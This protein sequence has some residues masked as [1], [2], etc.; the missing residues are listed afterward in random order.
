MKEVQRRRERD[1]SHSI[2]YSDDEFVGTPE[3]EFVDTYTDTENGDNIFLDAP[4]NYTVL[5]KGD[6]KMKSSTDIS[7]A[8]GMCIIA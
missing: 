6:E 5:K 8:T 4:S 3:D 1:F 7:E 2:D